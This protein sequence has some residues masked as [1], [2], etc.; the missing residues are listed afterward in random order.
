MLFRS[1]KA[2]SKKNIDFTSVNTKVS[3][4][5]VREREGERHRER[6][7]HEERETWKGET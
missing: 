2:L 3:T 1:K 6:E 4:L 7:R 5:K